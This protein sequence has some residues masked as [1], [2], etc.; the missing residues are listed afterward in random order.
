MLICIMTRMTKTGRF[1]CIVNI[2][3]DNNGE[4]YICSN[5]S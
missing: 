2:Y 4:I 3:C 1:I 5:N